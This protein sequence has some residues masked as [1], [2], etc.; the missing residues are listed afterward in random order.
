MQYNSTLSVL[1]NCRQRNAIAANINRFLERQAPPQLEHLHGQQLRQAKQ[2]LAACLPHATVRGGRSSADVVAYHH[3]VQLDVDEAH[4]PQLA[5]R[6]SEW[7]AYFA[8]RD[9]CELVGRSASGR[10]LC[11]W[12]R[13]AQPW[14]RDLAESVIDEVER[15]AAQAR[16]PL[17]CDRVNSV[18]AVALRFALRE[19]IAY[20]PDA[21]PL[22]IS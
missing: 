7:G 12:V 20:N 22:V 1:D 13:T 18:S 21:V 11:V 3:R 19:V 15:A 2:H 9:W 8:A 17:Q 6:L 10:G 5:G 4:N 14:T 16:R